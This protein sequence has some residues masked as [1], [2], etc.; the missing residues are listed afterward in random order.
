VELVE[1]ALLLVEPV[2]L[3]AA[4]TAAWPAKLAYPE[5]LIQV[6]VA[7]VGVVD[8]ALVALEVLAW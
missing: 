5:Q 4:L 2:V 6:V 7:V 8:Q 1:W 3:V